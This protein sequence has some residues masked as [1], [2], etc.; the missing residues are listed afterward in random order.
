MV[1]S[2]SLLPYESSVSVK[3][4]S[5]RKKKQKKRRSTVHLGHLLS[6]L[7]LYQSFV[8]AS[9]PTKVEQLEHEIVIRWNLFTY[10]VLKSFFESTNER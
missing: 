10:A 1:P 5:D 9:K 3:E 6:R 2:L 7:F 4:N 8:H